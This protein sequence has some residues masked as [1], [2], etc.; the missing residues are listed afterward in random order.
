MLLGDDLKVFLL[1]K[2]LHLGLV[3]SRFIHHRWLIAVQFLHFDT[4]VLL[5]L[6]QLENCVLEFRR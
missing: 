1:L 6:T 2:L 4:V 5:D 3:Y